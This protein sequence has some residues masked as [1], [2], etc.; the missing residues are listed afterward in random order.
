M[1]KVSRI[2]ATGLVQSAFVKQLYLAVDL[3]EPDKFLV[4]VVNSGV[5]AGSNDPFSGD[6]FNHI[7]KLNK[8]PKISSVKWLFTLNYIRLIYFFISK[9]TFTLK[10]FLSFSKRYMI[11][12]D[13]YHLIKKKYDIFHFHF[14]KG[15]Y[16]DLFWHL[17]KSDYCVLTFWGSDLLR[18]SDYSNFVMQKYAVQRANLITTHSV[19][20]REVILSKFGREHLG[21]IRYTKFPPHDTLYKLIREYDHLDTTYQSSLAKKLN[22][23]VHKK[24]IVVGHN[25]SPDNNHLNIIKSLAHLSDEL[26]AQIFIMLPFAYGPKNLIYEEQIIRS[27]QEAGIEGKIAPEFLS[28]EDLAKLKCLTDVMI[29]LPISDALSGAL[30][31]AWYGGASIITGAWLPYSPF[32][33]AGLI[34]ECVDEFHQLPA[35]LS[36][37]IAKG[38]PSIAQVETTRCAID[39]NFSVIPSAKT[40]VKVFE[41]EG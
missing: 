13:L 15:S 6:V 36:D 9:G 31:E 10:S 8:N 16:L 21:K 34:M 23:N 29:H 12:G 30:T 7:H 39:N 37:V 11:Y 35:V 18:T 2:L 22:F 1:V 38:K 4:D 3:V 33:N 20:M 5:T 40:W 24:L 19:E 26:K 41:D 28:W 27:L 14:P 25:S 32:K 17:K